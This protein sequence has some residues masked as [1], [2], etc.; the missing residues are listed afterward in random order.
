MDFQEVVAKRRMAR[1]FE[2]RPIPPEVVERMLRNA[3]RAPS[4]SN[5]EGWAFL[6][7]E[8]AEQTGR[9]FD[10]TRRETYGVPELF[11]AP[12]VIVC[13]SSKD[14]YL[15]RYALPDKGWIDRDESRWPAPYWDIDAG[16]AAMLILLTAEDQGLG[17][18]FF[19]LGGPGSGLR[20]ATDMS[21]FRAAYGIPERYRPIGAIAVGYKAKPTVDTS[22]R[23]SKRRSYEAV[24]HRG[25]W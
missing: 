20:G 16:M 25:R 23:P 12:L 17:A 2:D 9:F 14:A 4:A 13:L 19:G 21:E 18:L 15:D 22:R 5:I 11:Q 6:V 7:L 8:G 10:V 3:V 1:S 24:V